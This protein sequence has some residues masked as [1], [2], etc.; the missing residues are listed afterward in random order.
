MGTHTSFFKALAFAIGATAC[1][2][3]APQPVSSAVAAP[4]A[5]EGRTVH[6]DV[7]AQALA[8]C[9]RVLGDVTVTGSV[10][11]LEPFASVTSVWGTLRIESAPK[12]E[13]LDGL[14]SLRAASNLVLKRNPRLNSVRALRNLQAVHSVTIS[15]NPL[16]ETLSGLEGLRSLDSL[17]V[18]GNGIY[19]LHGLGNVYAVGDLVVSDNPRLYDPRG[20][21][22]VLEVDRIVL[23][24]NPRLSGHFGIL[25]NLRQ[26]PVIGTIAGNS[27]CAK[28]TSRLIATR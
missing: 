19:T 1:A 28:E 18:A 15:T 17:T 24:N 12:L 26:P 10:S 11:S 22:G 16:L 7:E 27:L 21:A 4:R 9:T 2:G 13:T 6:S 3:S 25:P 23:S 8:G 5:C 14:S 20:L